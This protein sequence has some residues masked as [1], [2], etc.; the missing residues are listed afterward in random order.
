MGP[1]RA[2]AGGQPHLPPAWRLPHCRIRAQAEQA[3]WGR[4]HG[5]GGGEICILR[6]EL[7]LIITFTALIKEEQAEGLGANGIANFSGRT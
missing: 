7:T 5:R 2:D 6:K 3:P 4:S 1:A